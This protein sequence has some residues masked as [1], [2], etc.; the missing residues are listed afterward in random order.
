MRP[1]LS[2]HLREEHA[3]TDNAGV[4]TGNSMFQW[5]AFQLVELRRPAT[6]GFEWREVDLAES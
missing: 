2:A 4:S 3:Q 5:G 1:I 6:R